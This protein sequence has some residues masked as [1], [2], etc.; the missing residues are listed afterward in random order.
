M[1][2]RVYILH[3]IAQCK[4]YLINK[5]IDPAMDPGDSVVLTLEKH[6]EI[7][8]QS[9][10]AELNSAQTELDRLASTI[11]LTVYFEDAHFIWLGGDE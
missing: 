3:E 11:D 8:S 4:Q 6:R 1:M 10:E 9:T 7:L 5:N 2:L